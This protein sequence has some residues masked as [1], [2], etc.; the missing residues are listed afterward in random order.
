MTYYSSKQT[1]VMCFLSAIA[2]V[3]LLMF[4]GVLKIDAQNNNITRD[5]EVPSSLQNNIIATT[6]SNDEQNSIDVYDKSNLSVVNI[7]TEVMGY[8]FFYEAMPMEGG[9]GSGFIFD[10]RGYI[11]TNYHVVKNAYKVSVSLHD[12]SNFDGNVVG[13]DE[14]NDI[15]LIKIDPKDSKLN[16]LSLGTSKGLKVGQKVLAIGN[17]F[18]FERTLSIGIISGL[19]RPLKSESGTI[20]Q[21]MIQTDAAINPGNSGGPLLNNVGQ[22]IG[23]NTMIYSP[24]GGSVGVGFAIPIDTAKRVAS[25]LI[26]YGEVKRG[27]ID[28]NLVPNFPSL[29]R[30]ANLSITTGL[31]V[32]DLDESSN[33]Y[34]SGLRGGDK[35]KA[36][37]V[38]NR[39]LYL[40]GDIITAI[41]DKKIKTG[42]DYYSALEQ[43]KPN[44]VVKVSIIRGRNKLD[45]D[46][47]LSSSTKSKK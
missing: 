5:K 13:V 12:G 37:Q 16:V 34:K 1:A 30:Y 2:V 21:D 7:N 47:T 42:E 22:V 41:N 18:A 35:Q 27:R 46:L 32:S 33:A 39:V 26:M 20:I 45:L 31:L 10:E 4:A 14:E 36:V 29:A 8:N 44:D 17:P 28:A 24:S 38:G 11:L 19:G 6:Y 15:A 40:G 3:F 43:S 23:I 25:D 9:A